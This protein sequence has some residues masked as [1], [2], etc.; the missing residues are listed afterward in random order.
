MKRLAYL[1]ENSSSTQV[2]HIKLKVEIG[3]RSHTSEEFSLQSGA[4][5][6]IPVI[7]GG[8]DDLPDPSSMTTTIEIT[9]NAGEKV[10]IINASQLNVSDDMP[11]LE[12][13]NEEFIRGG[14]GE[15]RFSLNNT[16]ETEI[17][18]V[19]ARG[20]QSSDEITFY[21]LDTDGNVLSTV[22]V[23]QNLGEG[24]VTLSNG[25][26]VARIPAGGVF[27][28][29]ITELP[30]PGSSPDNITVQVE[31]SK[32]H[33]KLGRPEEVTIN[34]LSTTRGV[35]LAETS[36]Y[37]EILSIT[38]ASSN[39]DEDIIITGQATA[40]STG[41]PIANVPLDLVIS[42]NSFDRAYTVDTDDNGAFTFT[43]SPMSGESGLYKVRA[44]HPDILDRP[45]QGEFVINRITVSPATIN[46]SIPLNYEKDIGIQAR[47]GDS[48]FVSNL[49]LVYEAADQPDGT[50]PEGVHITTG[51]SIAT[52][53]S[54][55]TA[56][57][58]FSIWA[59]N[60]AAESG[61]II[62][63]IKSDE[64]G[65]DSW[66]T[67]IINT[68]F[69]EAYPVLYFSPDHIETGVALDDM[70]TETIT[71]QN[72]GLA[73]LNNVSIEIVHQ[74]N[75]TPAPEWILLNTTP[76]LGSIPVGEQREVSM[77]FAPT[78]ANTDEGMYS[79]YL[80]VTSSNHQTTD[81]G[82]YVSV[83]RSGI[84]NA[85]FKISDI[86]TGTEDE[87][88]DI[89]QGLA[90]AKIRVQNEKVLTEEYT[91]TTDSLGETLFTDLATGIYKY[92]ITANNHQETTGRLWIKP[93]ITVN[94]KVLLD[95]NLVTV[96]WEV[97]ETT[98]QDT[99]EIVLTATYET[100]VPAPVV[101]AEPPSITLPDME[102]GDIYYGEFTLTNY[103]LVRADNLKFTVPESDQ[104]YKYEL[105]EGLPDSLGAKE[106][107][108]VPYRI[109]SLMSLYQQEEGTGGGGTCGYSNNITAAYEY[110]CA[111]GDSSSG[112]ASHTITGSISGTCVG[113][114]GSGSSS[115]GGG[116][117]TY[118]GGGISGGYG[119][120]GGSTSTSISGAPYCAP[121]LPR[122]EPADTCGG[123][124]ESGKDKD[125][126][127]GSTVNS[128]FKEFKEEVTDLSIKA[129]GGKISV[130]RRYYGNAW[131]W[132]HMRNNLILN[133][134]T[135]QL[136]FGTVTTGENIETIDKGGVIYEK[137]SV[138][139][140]I[141]KNDTNEIIRLGEGYALDSRWNNYNIDLTTGFIWQDKTG[142][143]K[144]YNET[145]QM[146]EYGTRTGI[147]AKLL[148]EPGE[149]GRLTGVADSKDRQVI[150]FQ[151]NTDNRITAVQDNTGRRVE[152]SYTDGLLSKVTD[153]MQYETLY[154]YN[155][156]GQ[157][158]GITYPEG[159]KDN[160][161]YDSGGNVT[162]VTNSKGNGTFFEYDYEKTGKQYYARITTTSGNI[163]EIYYDRNG[164]TE[165][166]DINGRTIKKIQ[167]D[168]R[169]EI[170]TDE[171]GNAIR[172]EYDEWDN[173]TKIIYPDGS[174][175]T[176]EYEHTFN[177]ITK[178]TDQN[179][180]ITQYQYDS[181]GN[182]TRK[183]EA[184]G[185]A[186]ERVTTYIYENDQLTSA[187]IQGDAN[188]ISATTAYTYDTNGNI[189]SITGPEG[190]K[191][192]FLL[193]DNQGNPIQIKDPR[194]Y[195]WTIDYD[196]R[197]R[198]VSIT[199]P[200]NDATTIQYDGA[201]NIT[202]V[203]N[204][205]LKSFNIEYDAYNKAVKVIDPYGSYA[206]REH[207]T[208][209]LPVLIIDEEGK[210]TQITYDNEKRLINYTDGAGNIITLNYD[211][212][213]ET[214]VTSNRPVSIEYP[215]YTKKL[216]YDRLQRITRVTDILDE[217][218]SHTTSYEYD[219]VGN[220]T[221]KT[222]QEGST[223]TYEYDA[224]NRIIK[225]TDPI[226][227]ITEY[228]YDDRGNMIKLQDPKDGVTQFEYDRNNR[229]VKET[230]PM[231]E[232]TVYEY[233]K[234]GNRT[235]VSDAKAQKIT[236]IYDELNRI[237][238]INYFA[239]DDYLNPTKTIDL[240]YNKLGRIL[241]YSDGT[242][243]A[244]Y[245][246][247]D[248]QRKTG[249][250]VDY[251]MFTLSY[252]YTYYANS[253]KKTFTGPAGI[254]YTYNYDNNNR[255][256]GMDIPG[257]GQ[258]TYNTYNWNSPSKITLPG[259]ATS[260]Y[261][262]TPLMQL[263]SIDVKDP[264]DNTFMNYAYTYSS[265]G[266]ITAKN[267]E[268][269]NY[270]YQYDE[271][272]RLTDAVN[273]PSD[274]ETYTY[275]AIGNR[276]TA[277][278][279]SQPSADSYT[280]NTNNELTELLTQN[281]ELINYSYDD[282][283]N[284]TQKTVGAQITNY[285]YDIEDRLVQVEDG[286]SSV[287]AEYYY[288]PFGRRLWKEVS[289]VRTYYF[290]SDEGLIGEYDASG[291]EIKTY[292]YGP[293]SIWGTNPMFQKVGTDYYWYI[294]DHL[295][296]PQVIIDTTGRVVWAATYDSFGNAQIST[297]E[298]ENNL[299]FA[300]QYYDGE[301][302]LHYNWFRYYD[303]VAGRYL[304]TDPIG[305]AGGD[306]NLYAYVT[307]NP[308][309]FVDPF[310]LWASQK[311][312]YVHQRA[313]YR[314]ISH[315]LP[316]NQRRALVKAQVYAD[317]KQ[318]QTAE[319]AYRHA[320]RNPSQTSEQAQ[321]LANAFV[322]SQFQKAWA[323]K[324]INAAL[325][326][327]AIALHALQDATSPA[328]ENFQ[329]W[330]GQESLLEEIEH[331]SQELFDPGPGSPMYEVTEEAWEWFQSGTLPEGD[332]FGNDFCN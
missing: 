292:G 222:D 83:T 104:Y 211:E 157:L 313:T 181:K 207:N 322:S 227:G 26:T 315:L 214:Y 71:F 308:V 5:A 221:S 293:D 178:Q 2:E 184:V 161:T 118:I 148:Y 191:T 74:G 217:N 232:E 331:V 307:N 15:V 216:Y 90:G 236:Y 309:N 85:L 82:V 256:S 128:A 127:V 290:Y 188:T 288:D 9:P 40:R 297:A 105:L 202:T 168:G 235:S 37:G 182:L 186:S 213:Q 219:L 99:Y 123:S 108:T 20:S 121:E 303:P 31:I 84:G 237:T 30:V 306:L 75:G 47:A 16:S 62:L 34:G 231:G 70:I 328:H 21:L 225:I 151:Y 195:T 11:V 50:L 166:I 300:G 22:P 45:V 323:A 196:D 190:N 59:D 210:K 116:T 208:D 316:Q 327:F 319:N 154:E 119:S 64:T 189:A 133:M 76:Y 63:K 279:S 272:Y 156:S 140:Q 252:S 212:S 244:T 325:F 155:S 67:I 170:I 7:V 132:E 271:L 285:I 86:Y 4:S 249:E 152:Y 111:N 136:I 270:A 326:E 80:R 193:F 246:Y 298:I 89:I 43:F 260:D 44:T 174:E 41:L 318:Y 247:D 57:L 147:T 49:R 209:K 73:D 172:K 129:P 88:G 304:R 24:T 122:E 179:G 117:V 230:R 97:V 198:P 79:Y 320:M 91:Q 36:Y 187:T 69:T 52:L 112:R 54:G 205:Y 224:L 42:L 165:Q 266:N 142:N 204:A 275:D 312:F 301:T 33:Y 19:T 146:T 131:H 106:R 77:T 144:K 321:A 278:F 32:I 51:D 242:T 192:E 107:I 240:T 68:E 125:N 27:T 3:G 239:A 55:E 92:R 137:G 273:P 311:G 39:G 241:S 145:G 215:T 93:G 255:L 12:I 110:E 329:P 251:G 248:L 269:G 183:T 124:K 65:S 176:Y 38:P 277:A 98:I 264:G 23:K 197:A 153:T 332:L 18:I 200:L 228:T 238:Q 6:T 280:Y 206:I 284:M 294:N 199:N 282:D 60:N 134:D 66:G 258:I 149:N 302:G 171:K 158:I 296:T 159:R 100:N 259:G 276:L 164:D 120:G 226:E 135:D 115:S 250:T 35:V 175:Q 233:D 58:G 130:L 48:T 324:D 305:F 72:K 53:G 254:T 287:I 289:G 139:S 201:D 267:T 109:T 102:A 167:K 141:Y 291:T 229:L 286:S 96:E 203:V 177:R 185:T 28:S 283:G 143:W 218:T 17:E 234:A 94:E 330:T 299:R 163:K 56:S 25:K 13:L 281:S 261:S 194:G 113:S 169:D 268:H 150:W 314:A 295:G 162:E 61:K 103:G 243:S 81:I 29:D 78:A 138:T 274:D 262:Y 257:Q 87:N 263:E 220:I 223:T 14:T 10:E 253:M 46:L 265:A 310:G 1:A 95:Y 101:V 317:S 8:Y 114:G 245:T 126:T 173:L 160:I 180:N